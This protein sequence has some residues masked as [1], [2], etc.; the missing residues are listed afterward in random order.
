MVAPIKLAGCCA[1]VMFAVF[2]STPVLAQQ[3]LEARCRMEAESYGI[4]SEQM[5]EY[6]DGCMLASGG[7][8]TAAPEQSAS[9]EAQCRQEAKD[10]GIAPEQQHDYINGCILSLGGS[11]PVESAAEESQED[12]DPAAA[13]IESADTMQ[14]PAAVQ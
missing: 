11:L 9:I 2:V 5:E 1:S 6:L 7:S 13:D 10:Y 4:P 12:V 8:L 3:D 14:D